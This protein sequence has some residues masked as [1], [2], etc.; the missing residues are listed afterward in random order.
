MRIPMQVCLGLLLL[1]QRQSCSAEKQ[2]I[3]PW[4]RQ[5]W[6]LTVFREAWSK[7]LVSNDWQWKGNHDS[8]ETNSTN[9]H[10]RQWKSR[11]RFLISLTRFL[12]LMTRE[13]Q[14]LPQL[15]LLEEPTWHFLTV[16]LTKDAHVSQDYHPNYSEDSLD[17]F[18]KTWIPKSVSVSLKDPV[19]R[20]RTKTSSNWIKDRRLGRRLGTSCWQEDQASH[21]R[22]R[23]Q[24]VS[25]P[26][27]PVS[28]VFRNVLQSRLCRSSRPRGTRKHGISFGEDTGVCIEWRDIRHCLRRPQVSHAD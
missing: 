17:L 14:Q 19:S 16:T 15:L 8:K 1:R 24:C 3:H 21:P 28:C 13:H 26:H 5:P 12:L 6:L 9:L 2:K 11:D 23:K 7:V 22:L 4:I 25:R 20:K 18:S 27:Q 10:D